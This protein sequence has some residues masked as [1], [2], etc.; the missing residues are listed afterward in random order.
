MASDIPEDGVPPERVLSRNGT[1]RF[2]ALDL[3]APA[4]REWAKMAAC[5]R[6]DYTLRAFCYNKSQP[7]RVCP[8]ESCGIQYLPLP[9]GTPAASP[10]LERVEKERRLS[11]FCSVG[12]FRA[13]NRGTDV[14][15]GCPAEKGVVSAAAGIGVTRSA[16]GSI[17]TRIDGPRHAQ[18]SVSTVNAGGAASTTIQACSRCSTKAAKSLSLCS[19]CR[20]AAYCSVECQRA[21]WKTHKALCAVGRD[22]LDALRAAQ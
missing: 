22:A 16:D 15:F 6:E 17:T 20:L 8:F 13:V 11:G 12:C 3:S 18:R 9:E 5:I 7:D 4:V 1:H 2:F 10:G 14:D 21:D 19:A